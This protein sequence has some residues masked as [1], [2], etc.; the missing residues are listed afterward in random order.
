MYV[1]ED[2]F[3]FYVN[4]ETWSTENEEGYGGIELINP[5]KK[6]ILEALT[7]AIRKEAGELVYFLNWKDNNSKQYTRY[8]RELTEIKATK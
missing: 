3:I 7:Q 2:I 4:M 8:S 6:K 5:Q 1:Q